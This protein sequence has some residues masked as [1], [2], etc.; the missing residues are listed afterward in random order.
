MAT[1][2]YHRLPTEYKWSKL[3][4]KFQNSTLWRSSKQKH[5]GVIQSPNN[6]M[7][8][9]QHGK[10][11]GFNFGN[12]FVYFSRAL[13]CN[14]WYIYWPYCY[15]PKTLWY[16]NFFVIYVWPIDWEW[17]CREM[18][19]L[20]AYHHKLMTLGHEP[21]TTLC[22][23]YGPNCGHFLP[24]IVT[25]SCHLLP[26]FRNSS[27]FMIKNCPKLLV[28]FGLKDNPFEFQTNFN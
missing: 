2:V 11:F 18:K 10:Y 6:V 5:L 21:I 23:G 3:L 15:A 27:L 14:A 17:T 16:W 13:L 19:L 7:F 22:E 26:P 1:A 12:I 20:C 24:F 28:H 4:G 9:A 25:T 8:E